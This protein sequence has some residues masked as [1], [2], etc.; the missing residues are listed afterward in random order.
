MENTKYHKY[1]H[2]IIKISNYT[3]RIKDSDIEIEEL[4]YA[5]LSKQ[6]KAPSPDGFSNEFL[7]SFVEDLK[8]WIL[9]YFRE[10]IENDSFSEIAL[11]GIIT[12][13]P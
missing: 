10:T 4:E 1:F 6:N 11:E 12:C 3:K 8:H 2:N 9:R 5:K 7:K 13:I